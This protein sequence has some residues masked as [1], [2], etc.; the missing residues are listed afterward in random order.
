MT[1]PDVVGLRLSQSGNPSSEGGPRGGRQGR[2]MPTAI[3]G[4]RQQGH[5]LRGQPLPVRDP[6]TSLLR[7]PCNGE[8]PVG[9]EVV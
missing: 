7:F 8:V 9:T 1:S 5:L 2:G 4:I 6:A 3:A